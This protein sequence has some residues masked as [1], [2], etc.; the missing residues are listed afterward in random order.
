M[1]Y[2]VQCV[3]INIRKNL[4]KLKIVYIG[5]ISNMKIKFLFQVIK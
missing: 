1:H 3:V 5:N 2:Y 4:G